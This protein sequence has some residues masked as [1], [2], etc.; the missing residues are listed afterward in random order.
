MKKCTWRHDYFFKILK[1]VRQREV[2]RH[3]RESEIV[4]RGF[5]AAGFT[6]TFRIAVLM[7]FNMSILS[8]T[9]LLN[10]VGTCCMI[11]ATACLNCCWKVTKSAAVTIPVHDLLLLKLL[12][13]RISESL[14]AV[15]PLMALIGAP[16]PC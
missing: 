10:S 15:P 14:R 6:L 5:A 1:R 9:A 7:L 4:K 16:L 11:S 2:L 12:L 3:V 13:L 8:L